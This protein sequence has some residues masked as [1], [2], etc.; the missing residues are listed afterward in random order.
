MATKDHEFLFFLA[1][2]A[3]VI[4]CHAARSGNAATAAGDGKLS[5]ITVTA[6]RTGKVVE[7]LPEYE[8]T[9]ANGCGACPQNGVRVSCPA[10]GVQSVE[11]ADESKIRADEA[12]LGLVNDA[13]CRWR[14]ARR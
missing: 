4:S 1:A 12:G 8:V 9:V 14:R 6:A 11:P 5:G 7:G 3:I 13:I 2:A 10:G